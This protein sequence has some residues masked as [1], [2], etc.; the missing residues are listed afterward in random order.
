MSRI[1]GHTIDQSQT[2]EREGISTRINFY[3]DGYG[4]KLSSERL[5]DIGD[6]LLDQHLRDQDN[7]TAAKAKQLYD[8]Y[9][10]PPS[11]EIY[12]EILGFLL[13]AVEL[14]VTS[15]IE[16]RLRK[17]GEPVFPNAL[18]VNKSN[19]LQVEVG[20]KTGNLLEALYPLGDDEAAAG[21]YLDVT[22]EGIIYSTREID[23]ELQLGRLEAELRRCPPSD[24]SRAAWLR[25]NI[26]T[27]GDGVVHY[28]NADG[29][30]G[31]PINFEF[32]EAFFDEVSA[33][34]GYYSRLGQ[35][36]VHWRQGLSDFGEKGVDCDLI[37]QVMDDLHSGAVD[38]F[39]FMTNDMD[40]FP[41]VERLQAEGKHVFLCGLGGNVSYR[42]IEAVGPDAFFDLLDPSFVDNL[43]AV[44]M[45][46]V[47][48]DIKPTALQWAW[49]AMRRKQGRPS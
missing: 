49:L 20:G 4:A 46:M 30:V 5:Y 11:P 12:A 40:F 48:A 7:L 22:C 21:R 1:S 33:R 27:I 8:M 10:A 44:F 6:R 26:E 25:K 43:P 17:Q 34:I 36:K 32:S 13:S 9:Y 29:S 41:L 31:R 3:V 39:V 47:D 19:P 28:R 18:L 42:L 45:G 14:S 23:R 38:V 15:A 37:M 35:S 2:T 24:K 16:E